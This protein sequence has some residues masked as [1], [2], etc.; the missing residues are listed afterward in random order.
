MLAGWFALVTILAALSYASRFT[1]GKPP[2]D[3]LYRYGTAISGLIF[4]AVTLAVVLWLGSVLPR[5]R[6]GLRQPASWSR[7]LGLAVALLIAVLIVEV[8]LESILH[9]GRE[10]GLEP[11]RWEPDRAVPFALNAAVLVIAAPVV[12]ELTFRGVGFALLA[13]FGAWVAVSGTAAAFA[14]DHG[15]VAGFLPLFV[16]GL[17]I[18]TLRWRT[19]SVYP[20][21][22]FH[23]CFNGL[24]LAF[25]FIR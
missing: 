10:Q 14:A 7:A 13:P 6:L 19:R 12:E 1:A 16:F 3:T 11:P 18:A 20:G 17:A 23:A 2:A 22:L 21:M 24:V 5:H 15:L 8:A 9:A 25:A 4:Y